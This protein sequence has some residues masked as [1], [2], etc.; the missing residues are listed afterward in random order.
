MR[1]SDQHPGKKPLIRA[2]IY[3]RKSTEEGLEQAFN[4]LDAQ[5]EACEAFVKSQQHEGWTALPTKYNDGGFTGGNIDRP[6]LQRL[7]SDVDAGRVDAVVTYKLDRLSRSIKDFADMMAR[8]EAKGVVYVSITQQINTATAAGR[9]LQNVLVTFAQFEREII[10]ERTRDK[11]KLTKMKG[12]WCGGTPPL[13][14][15]RAEK[16]GAL[17]VNEPEAKR[18]RE[19][20]QMYLKERSLLRVAQ[21]LNA[22]GWR[23]KTWTTR[24]GNLHEGHEFTKTMLQQLLRNPVYIGLIAHKGE[25]FKG[26]HA[27]IVDERV[28]KAVQ[29]LLASGAVEVASHGPNPTA[30]MLKGLVHCA[31]CGSTMTAGT[32]SNPNA[33]YRY[34]VCTKAKKQGVLACP[35]RSV[36]A[37]ELEA[38]V[39]DRLRSLGRDPELVAE[40]IERAKKA[41]QDGVPALKAEDRALAVEVQKLK[42][43]AARLVAALTGPGDASATATGKLSEVE[44][45][46]EQFRARQHEIREE[47]AALGKAVVNEADAR[48]ALELF[49]P[50]WQHLTLEERT[51]LVRTVV[52]RVEYDGSAGE[53]EI[54]FHPLGLAS[55]AEELKAAPEPSSPKETA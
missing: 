37:P 4:S 26:E 39:V 7:L 34:Y 30:Y 18:V 53:I 19:I 1:P 11:I 41:A 17:V 29:N 38:F 40:V 43:E 28:W 5:R 22:R 12:K 52:A 9:L 47:I 25:S 35:T 27:A 8:F 46:V 51:R 44:R 49:D 20:F 50:V 14:Y 21:I 54:R 55:L 24:K 2:A 31:A 45:Q 16:G 13:G 36:P 3:T 33:R 15:D 6:A 32:T 48:A 23:S 42:N 10:S